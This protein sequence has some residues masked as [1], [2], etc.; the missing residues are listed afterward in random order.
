MDEDGNFV[1]QEFYLEEK[2][3]TPKARTAAN[4]SASTALSFEP[5]NDRDDKLRHVEKKFLLEKFNGKQ[6]ASDWLE[7]MIFRSPTVLIFK[8][9]F[10]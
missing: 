10:R 1:F 2:P 7:F 9:W 3:D 4:E 5:A 6:K 8:R